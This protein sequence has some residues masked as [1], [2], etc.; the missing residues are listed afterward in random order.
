[1]TKAASEKKNIDFSRNKI[2]KHA[3]IDEEIKPQYKE[4]STN[5]QFTGN[6]SVSNFEELDS[7]K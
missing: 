7:E 5:E 2:L 1:M 4:Q 3:A 6:K